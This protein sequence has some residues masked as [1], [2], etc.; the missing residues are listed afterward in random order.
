MERQKVS[1]ED[2]KTEPKAN[3]RP[4]KHNKNE[5]LTG[6]IQELN[7]DERVSKCEHRSIES[8]QSKKRLKKQ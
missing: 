5:K 3:F 2:I 6:W 4:E 8:I 1:I 7:G